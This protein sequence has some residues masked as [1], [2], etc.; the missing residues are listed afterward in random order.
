MAQ[1]LYGF[2]GSTPDDIRSYD[3]ARFAAAMSTLMLDGVACT[4][5]HLKVSAEGETMR[6]RVEPGQAIIRGYFYELKDDGGEITMLTINAHGT[7]DRI[8][9]IV[10]RL[11]IND[12]I[13]ALRV[14]NGTAAASPE[15]PELLR[16]DNEYDIS[17]AQVYVR[18]GAASIADG[19]I[20]DERAKEAVCGYSVPAALKLSE[21][22]DRMTKRNATASQSGA[23]SKEDKAALDALN[24]ALSISGNAINVGGRYIDNALF[25]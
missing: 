12:K 13:I 23:M 14:V 8:A 6:V 20:T 10:L 1:E 7:Y 9:R 15:P 4:G 19:D 2:F 5:N 21:V 11:N 16:N 3:E 18:A 22:W 25:R 24:A 17:L